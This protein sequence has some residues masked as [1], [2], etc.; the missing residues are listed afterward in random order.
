[1]TTFHVH[2]TTLD[3]ASAWVPFAVSDGTVKPSH[4]AC[5]DEA[6][7]LAYGRLL[8]SGTVITG[9]DDA[10][11]MIARSCAEG[12]ACAGHTFRALVIEEVVRV[13]REIL[14]ARRGLN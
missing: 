6:G 2:P 3:G 4:F 14:A 10:E 1:M 9:L 5:F 13:G 8:A 12:G 11:A 7:A